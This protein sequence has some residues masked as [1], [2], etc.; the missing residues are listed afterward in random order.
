M[1]I[2]IDKQFAFNVGTVLRN[3]SRTLFCD[4][5]GGRLFSYF[6]WQSKHMASSVEAYPRYTVIL[7]VTLGKEIKRM[8]LARRQFILTFGVD[9]FGETPGREQAISWIQQHGGFD[10][11]REGNWKLAKEAA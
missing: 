10:R 4:T 7:E 11:D 2:V 3:G 6:E 5:P 8:I 9:E 1:E